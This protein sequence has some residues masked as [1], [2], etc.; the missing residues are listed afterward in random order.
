MKLLNWNICT[1]KMGQLDRLGKIYELDPDVFCLQELTKESLDYL[2]RDGKYSIYSTEDSIHKGGLNHYIAVGSKFPITNTGKVQYDTY[3]LFSPFKYLFIK[4]ANHIEKHDAIYIDITVNDKAVRLYCL[5]L[6]LAT[7]PSTRIK[8]F[9]T[10]ADSLSTNKFNIICGDFN[11]MGE[12]LSI[13]FLLLIPF[14]YK[15]KD[16]FLNERLWFSNRFKELRLN[17]VFA[18]SKSMPSNPIS[19]QLD[20]VLIPEEVEVLFKS[21]FKETLQSDHI[22]YFLEF[23]L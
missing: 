8:Q 20:H 9:S 7:S 10:L 13:N 18:Y 11:I 21:N 1:W 14:F 17:N 4:L 12:F 23:N 22:P 6:T 19:G 3:D 2:V 15:L 16:L 5:H